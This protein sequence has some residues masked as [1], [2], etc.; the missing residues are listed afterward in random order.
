ML[1]ACEE[2]I[3]VDEG[4]HSNPVAY[5]KSLQRVAKAIRAAAAKVK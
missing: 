5:R 1:A 2:F 3:K 4:D